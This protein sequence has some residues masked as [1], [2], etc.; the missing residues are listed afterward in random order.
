[1]VAGLLGRLLTEGCIFLNVALD[2]DKIVYCVLWQRVYFF[3]D[4][5]QAVMRAPQRFRKIV[6]PMFC[7][8]RKAALRFLDLQLVDWSVATHLCVLFSV[9]LVRLSRNR[10]GWC[11]SNTTSV[12]EDR[13][14]VRFGRVRVG[15]MCCSASEL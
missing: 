7:D 10:S 9:V 8:V 6:F 12:Y 5:V 1:M 15:R 2:G 14:C 11:I 13:F 4:A 3:V